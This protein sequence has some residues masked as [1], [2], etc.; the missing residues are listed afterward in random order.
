[1]QKSIEGGP[2]NYMRTDAS[3]IEKFFGNWFLRICII[4]YLIIGHTAKLILWPTGIKIE[5]IN[6]NPWPYKRLFGGLIRGF[7]EQ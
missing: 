7:D 2:T 4:C 6:A 3:P 5:Y 1:M